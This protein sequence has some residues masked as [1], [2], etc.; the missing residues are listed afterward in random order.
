MPVDFELNKYVKAMHNRNAFAMTNTIC[1]VKG[2]AS[3]A[4]D[5]PYS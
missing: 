2:A 1:F 5:L 3:R 4:E